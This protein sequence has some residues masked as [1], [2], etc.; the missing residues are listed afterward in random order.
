MNDK[1]ISLPNNAESYY[2]LA[3]KKMSQQLF[4]DAIVYLKKALD[5][6][7]SRD[8]IKDLAM[9]YAEIGQVDIGAGYIYECIVTA[10]TFA[11]YFYILSQLYTKA[12]EPNKAFLFG[13]YYV[14][15]TDDQSYMAELVK[16]FD[17]VY[18][19][20]A[21]VEAESALFVTQQIFQY[22]FSRGRINESI[23]WISNQPL[24]LQARKEMRNLK[25]MA[26]LFMSRYPEAEALLEQLL[27]EDETDIHALCHYTLLLYNTHQHSKY[28]HYIQRLNKLHPISE[29]ESFKLG[30]VL[31][32]LKQYEASQ[33]LLLPIYK[34]KMLKNAQLYHALS[35]NY[36]A[37]GDRTASEEMWRQL[38][39]LTGNDTPSPRDIFEGMR[40]LEE[41]VIP[42][43]RSDDSH[44]RLLGIFLISQ[45]DHKETM[46]SKELWDE[47]E[48]MRD[49][50]KL[51]LS[52][53]FH[54]LELV[55]L[56][57]I[58]KGLQA[59]Y[60]VNQEHELLLAW[61][62]NAEE[63]IAAKRPLTV[64]AYA[65]ATYY[66]YS[67]VNGTS[68]SMKHCAELFNTTHYQFTK[69][70]EFFKQ[71]NV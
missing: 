40:Y 34:K 18:K 33:A 42:L 22:L 67:K 17:V 29:D 10:E 53:I 25:A 36:Y 54:Q 24:A 30:I 50:E 38:V 70:Y 39:R 4:K 56:D 69:A 64:D 11:D 71:N 31:C 26:Y 48:Q 68:A 61:I 14:Q 27:D 63:V 23:D 41:Q 5:H 9:C 15:L 46:I 57:F 45:L 19:N 51:Y 35:F 65:A 49:Y 32:Y 28:Q 44:H 43:L 20:K 66:A 47:L 60:E 7:Q 58:H 6:Q 1:I 13:L 55:K 16:T 62:D 2:L 12:R 8:Y 52:Y 21:E 3:R 59:L 37:L